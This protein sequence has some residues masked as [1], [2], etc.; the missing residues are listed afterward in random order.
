MIIYLDI[1]ILENLFMNY[2]IL[3]ATSLITKNKIKVWRLALSSLLGGVYAAV[4]YMSVL[5]VYSGLG[6]KILLSIAMIYIAFNSKSIKTLFKQLV[7]FYLVSFAFGGTAFAL[8]YFIRPQDILSKNGILIGTYPIKVAFLG[9]IVGFTI[10]QIAF[11]SIKTRMTKKDMFCNIEIWLDGLCVKVKGMIDTGNLLKEPIT[12][13]PVI[14]VESEMLTDILPESIL[15]NVEKIVNGDNYEIDDKYISRFRV[16]PFSSI[17]KEN[18]LLLGIKSDKIAINFE[19]ETKEE[20]GVILGIYKSKLSKNNL[21]NALI[22][23][24]LLEGSTN[25]YIRDVKV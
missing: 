13:T 15:E 16:I 2:L 24:E 5:K 10:I 18:G 12:K 8:L 21:Y 6:L 3:F 9:A 4:S 23:L 11:K 22:G 1:V 20:K 14:V 25:E 7:I 17:G 19:E